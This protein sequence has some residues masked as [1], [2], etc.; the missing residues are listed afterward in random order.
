MKNNRFT[1]TVSS[2]LDYQCP[3]W[4]RDA[5]FGIYL[6]W[7][8]YSVAEQGEWYPRN[9]YIEGHPDYLH[10]LEHY[11]HPSKFGYKDLVGL[12]KAE[13]WDPGRLVSLFK[14][15]GARYFTPCAVHH[16]NFD[17]WNSRHNRW[18]SVEMGPKRDIIGE[19]RKAALEQGLRFGVTTH[20]ERTWSWLQTNKGADR[21]GPEAGTAYD[22][23]DP[24]FRDFYLAPSN[25]TDLRHPRNAP[26]SWRDH[27]AERIKDLIDNYH[28]DHLY[29]DGAIPFMGEDN[30]RTG[31]DVIS[32]LYNH[33]M[34][35]HEGSQEAVMCIKNISDH[36]IYVD[37][38]TTL[39]LERT[40]L[41]A[42]RE[43]PWQTDT[44]IGPWG[45]RAGASYRPVSALVHELV[46][47]VSKNGNVLLNVPPKADGT[48]DW[49]TEEIL[50]GIG[51]WLRVNGEAIFETRPWTIFGRDSIRFTRKR[52]RLYLTILEWPENGMLVVPE[53]GEQNG[54]GRIASVSMLGHDSPV[55]WG[56]DSGGRSALRV[57]LP[58]TKPCEHAWSFE[59]QW[60]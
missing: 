59:I 55:R 9:M 34:D 36:G 29:F 13:E 4:F 14:D 49:E 38:V 31:M 41:D 42:I 2:L 16:D 23:N 18:N 39:D 27:W 50:A 47:I 15:S 12:W 43:L 48:L 17:L 6:H 1:P 26:V 52:D 8:A 60:R 40:K 11:G 3:E 57:V 19:W 44:S 5:K 30:G 20:L 28:P 56:Q 10:Q 22:G 33:S 32:H 35:I 58:E 53:L 24:A 25:D 51:S 54:I 45:Y 21:S 46:D 37:G 7:G